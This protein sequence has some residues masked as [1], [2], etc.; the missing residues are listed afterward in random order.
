MKLLKQ[1]KPL[2]K[3]CSEGAA[4]PLAMI[5]TMPRSMSGNKLSRMLGSDVRIR[6]SLE[7]YSLTLLEH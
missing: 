5:V 2:M 6:F 1:G 3:E 4:T 7:T